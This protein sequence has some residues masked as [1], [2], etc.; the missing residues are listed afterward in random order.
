[1]EGS[2]SCP[3]FRDQTRQKLCFHL[4]SGVAP[5]DRTVAEIAELRLATAAAVK[6]VTD[7]TAVVPYDGD[8]KSKRRLAAL[9]W[10][11]TD[12]IEGRLAN[13]YVV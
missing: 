11:W 1:M 10:P 3:V 12:P 6:A 8:S 7:G 5:A 4:I 9:L 2:T 13:I